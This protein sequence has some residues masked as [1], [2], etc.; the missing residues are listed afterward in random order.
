LNLQPR[1]SMAKRY[2]VT[3]VRTVIVRYK[4]AEGPSDKVRD[5]P[6]LER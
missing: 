6:V 2:R 3:Q 4:L 5:Y 1:G